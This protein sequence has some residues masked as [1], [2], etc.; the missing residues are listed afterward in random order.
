MQQR[1]K[2]SRALV[3]PQLAGMYNPVAPASQGAGS[4]EYAKQDAKEGATEAVKDQAKD[5][6]KS[7]IG[8]IVDRPLE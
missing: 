6:A 8:K 5:K 3:A 7:A 4:S 1:N 2:L